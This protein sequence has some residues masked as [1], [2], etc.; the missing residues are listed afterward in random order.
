[1]HAL[2]LGTLMTA[3]SSA[4]VAQEPVA[5]NPEA[6]AVEFHS[7]SAAEGVSGRFVA[8]ERAIYFETARLPRDADAQTEH[9]E[10]DYDLALRLTD[11]NGRTLLIMTEGDVTPD[12][13][14]GAAAD[15]EPRPIDPG[16]F[17]MAEAA[18]QGVGARLGAEAQV[19]SSLL[20]SQLALLSSTA[21]RKPS[22]DD[23][24]GQGTPHDQQ[25]GVAAAAVY[26]QGI[27][28]FWKPAFFNGSPFDH[29]GTAAGRWVNNLGQWYLFQVITK[30]N[31]GTCPGDSSMTYYKTY[32]GMVV[33]SMVFPQECSGPYGVPHVCN[34]DTLLQ[35][36]NVLYNSSYNTWLDVACSF[37]LL[38][39]P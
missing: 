26:Q 20:A 31:H 15:A 16:I 12:G 35:Q 30:C 37:T 22:S 18:A 13:W 28:S 29:T 24:D 38:W 9:P 39:R 25:G 27:D 33:S 11:G 3:V 5:I 34:N 36:K 2:I 23:V 4:P 19:E 14:N 1:M 10:R 21:D 6:I 17:R 32:W 8:G 7:T